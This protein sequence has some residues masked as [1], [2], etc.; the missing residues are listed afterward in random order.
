MIRYDIITDGKCH[1]KKC[2]L[3]TMMKSYMEK[4]KNMLDRIISY[5]Y[6]RKGPPK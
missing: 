5:A 1:E 2:R 3:R 4:F 6:N